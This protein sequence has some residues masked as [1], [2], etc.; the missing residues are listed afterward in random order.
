MDNSGKIIL[1]NVCFIINRKTG[2]ILLIKRSK[3]PMRLMYTGVGGKTLSKESPFDSCIRE[4]KE[5][6]GLDVFEVN[7]RGVIKTILD[8]DGSSWILSV[9][10][11][12]G[13]SGEMTECNEGNL[14]WV[15]VSSINSYKLIGFI[16]KIIPYV[17]DD[18]IIFD[19]L[20]IHDV[21]G[22]VI[23]DSIKTY[24]RF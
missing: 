24:S 6:T 7:F 12:A 20:I 1:G 21:K 2:R 18:R 16:R 14:E 8:K 15:D 11:A 23:E 4:V 9:Y 22:D 3:E 19:G 5:E 17:L 13:F 10:T